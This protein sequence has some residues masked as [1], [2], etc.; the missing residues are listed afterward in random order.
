MARPARGG[1][2][3]RRAGWGQLA[4]MRTW[5]GRSVPRRC[6][7]AAAS[8]L[9]RARAGGAARRSHARG[10]Q[11]AGLRPWVRELPSTD[12][13][14]ASTFHPAGG[15]APG[16]VMRMTRLVAVSIHAA[17]A[18]SRTALSLA[19]ARARSALTRPGP[20]PTKHTSLP[21]RGR[22]C[23][24]VCASGVRAPPVPV[25]RNAVSRFVTRCSRLA[26]AG[27]GGL[28]EPLA[29]SRTRA[30]VASMAREAAP[31]HPPKSLN[32]PG[33]CVYIVRT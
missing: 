18:R 13:E 22:R 27:G 14:T 7:A 10:A 31:P 19:R 30:P 29:P 8:R 12:R 16:T 20:S 11:A 17:S 28:N 33:A 32:L 2:A 3:A 26:F 4:H 24:R 6:R 25:V 5:G 1:S 21:A 23:C 9:R 15:G